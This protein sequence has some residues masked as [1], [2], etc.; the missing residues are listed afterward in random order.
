MKVLLTGGTGLIG[1]AL[2]KAMQRRGWQVT[3]LTR[4]GRS[5]AE[6][7]P[8]VKGDV[9]DPASL[10]AAMT[11]A[12]LV[13]HNAGI[14]ELVPTPKQAAEMRAVN[15][16]G[17][18]NVLALARE[19]KTPRLVYTSTTVVVG[20]TGGQP[21]DETFQRRARPAY[22][23]EETK[24][25]AHALAVQAQAEGLPLVIVCPAQVIGPGDHSVFGWYGRLYVRGLLPPVIWGP[26]GAFTY[27][28]VDDVAEGMALAAEKGR[29][30]EVYFLGNRAAVTM[31][32]LMPIWKKA[33][34]GLAPFIW[35]PRPLAELQG[36]LVE[37][38]LRLFGLP[39]FIS[40][41]AVVNTYVSYRYSSAKAERELGWQV[42]SGEQAWIDTLR[43][44]RDLARG[45]AAA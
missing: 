33:V 10:R 28:Y 7:I 9:T 39:A 30:G 38:V 36:A 11:G 35:L 34:G 1:T 27:V 24:T 17:T 44:E 4:S 15:V 3:A 26:D 12:D 41:T 40:R 6:G 32:E 21:A 16:E 19:L 31:R 43:A 14:Y 42:R 29:A 2:A 13:F 20:D 45:K 23:Y 8:G 5:P 25:E 22:L 37:P 18:R